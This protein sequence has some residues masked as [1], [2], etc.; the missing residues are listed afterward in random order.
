MKHRKPNGFFQNR[1]LVEHEEIART[2]NE[3]VVRHAREAIHTAATKAATTTVGSQNHSLK[4][5]VTGHH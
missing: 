2:A 4:G 1:C 5:H 3:R